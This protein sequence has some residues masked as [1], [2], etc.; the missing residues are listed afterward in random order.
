MSRRDQPRLNTNTVFRK[1]Q[2]LHIVLES[3]YCSNTSP[4]SS[5][6]PDV[7][8]RS[9]LMNSLFKRD[10]FLLCYRNM[11]IRELAAV[12]VAVL[13]CHLQLTESQVSARLLFRYGF[14]MTSRS[15]LFHTYLRIN[16]FRRA[17]RI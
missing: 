2:G 14:S 10:S 15:T 17:K 4:S 8:E 3:C 7:N 12:W 16:I 5:L 13:L 11:L 9:M 6:F 1:C